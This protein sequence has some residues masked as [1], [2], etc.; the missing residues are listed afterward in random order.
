VS[1]PDDTRLVVTDLDGTLLDE[2]TYDFAPARPGLDALRARRIGLVLCSS[3]TR[4]EMESLAGVLGL[5]RPLGT[6]LIVENGGAVVLRAR[7]LPWIP[8]EG[9]RDGDQVV[10]ALGTP[11]AALLDA[12]PVVA[13]EAGVTVRSFAA[14]AVEEVATLTGL[15]PEAARRARQREWDEPFVVDGGTDRDGNARLEEAARRRGLRVTRGGRFHHLTGPADKG[16]ALRT[17]LRLLPLDP[18]GRVV[19]L[20]DA[21]NDLPMLEVVDRP[22]LM[23]GRDDE[24]DPVLTA[25]L[26]AAERAPGPGPAGWAAAVVAVLAGEALP[27][28]AA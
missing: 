19:G 15:D 8:P 11:R 22:I 24:L 5:E 20:G 23:P 10:F 28:V 17:L 26:P 1:S 7:L 14:M 4:T 3:K 2:E 9:R 12:L 13:D 6:P 16:E 18:H 25:A 21:A 27:R